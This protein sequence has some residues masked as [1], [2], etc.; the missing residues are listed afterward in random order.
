MPIGIHVAKKSHLGEKSYKNIRDAIEGESKSFG[1]TAVQIFTHGPR[2]KNKNQMNYADIRGYCDEHKIE[3]YVHASY[4]SISIWGANHTNKKDNKSIGHIQ[5]IY[6]MLESSKDLAARGLV[7]HLPKRSV[8]SIVETM[9]V[10]SEDGRFHTLQKKYGK[11]PIV[12][13]MPASKPDNNTYETPEKLNRLV[14][15]LSSN[16]KINIDWEL[17]IDTAHQYSCAVNFGVDWRGW[18]SSLSKTALDKISLIHLNGAD[19]KNYGSGKDI[20]II[21]TSRGDA[22]WGNIIS[23]DMREF[24]NRDTADI[25]KYNLFDH[26][27]HEELA[28][29]K[30]STLF[31]IIKFAKSRGVT[32]ICEIG[33]GTAIEAKLSVD[34]LNGLS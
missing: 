3:I 7:L 31:D 24:I 17:C 15:A 20:H 21:A 1:L 30:N 28:E 18:V 8:S 9:E 32:V 22:I 19:A 2:T 11:L 13:E 34:I 26:L 29:I 16:K 5:H 14:D 12:L 25:I 4:L 27:S 33:R 10:L 6:D 23:R